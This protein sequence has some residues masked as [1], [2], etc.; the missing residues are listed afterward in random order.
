MIICCGMHGAKLSLIGII[1]CSLL[2]V[3]GAAVLALFSAPI[4]RSEVTRVDVLIVKANEYRTEDFSFYSVW[5]NAVSFDVLNGTIKS[6]EPLTEAQYLD[7]Q[8]GRY[9]PNWTET[10]HATYEYKGTHLSP[11]L[12]GPFYVRYL[13]F[14]NEDPY[15]KVVNWHITSY[16]KEPNTTNLTWGSVLVAMGLVASLSLTLVYILKSSSHWPVLNRFL[17]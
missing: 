10:S 6:C 5:D 3:S 4:E 14:Y 9:M 12:I 17:Y 16:W 13:L 1:L 2:I 7:W 15:D 11:P 8:A